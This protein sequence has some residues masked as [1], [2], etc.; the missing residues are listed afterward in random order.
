VKLSVSSGP[1]TPPTTAAP[2]P[3]P[4]RGHGKPKHGKKDD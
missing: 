3:A 1:A 2:P 4:A